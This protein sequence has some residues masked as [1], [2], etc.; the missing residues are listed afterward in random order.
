MTSNQSDCSDENNSFTLADGT[1]P[2]CD[3]LIQ[4]YVKLRSKLTVLKKA[5]VDL[6]EQS[7]QK[8]KSLRKHEQELEALNFR[9]Q[10]LTGRVDTLQ[11]QLD[12]LGSRDG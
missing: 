1:G 10:Q 11:R 2:K 3:K 7:S 4:D 8:D 12:S 6:S 9:N 5:Y